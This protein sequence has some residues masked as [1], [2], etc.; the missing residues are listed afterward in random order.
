MAFDPAAQLRIYNGALLMLGSRRLATLTDDV[1]S[2][3][4]LDQIWDNGALKRVLQHGWWKHAMR[5]VQ[6]TYDPD[7]T[8]SFG[9]KYSFDSPDDLVRLY[10]MCSDEFFTCPID[11]YQDEGK[12]WFCDYTEIF[13]RYVSDGDD[14]GLDVTKWPESFTEYVEGYMALKAVKRITDSQADQEELIKDVRLLK[15]KAKSEDALR[16]PTGFVVASGWSVARGGCDNGR[17]KQHPY[18]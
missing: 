4:V 7:F 13:L 5:T 2:R 15:T 9:Y 6:L 3:Y 10:S 17:R 18:R 11:Q 14:Y 16:E 8:S 12:K 1:E